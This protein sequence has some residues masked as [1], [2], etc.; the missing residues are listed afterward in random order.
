MERYVS[1]QPLEVPGH[2][3]LDDLSRADLVFYGVDHSGPSYEA[4]VFIDQPDATA[5]TPVEA[6]H[7]YAGSFTVFGHAGCYGDPGHCDPDQGFHDA[8]DRR[9][10]HPLTPYTK[11]VLVTEALKRAAKAEIS[12]SVIPIMPE[13][14]GGEDGDVLRF[15]HVRLLTYV[16]DG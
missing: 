11:T 8:F 1:P 13:V 7:G 6:E 12:I 5:E 16:D 9:P 14:E 3:E 4:R 15:D 2:E 10:P